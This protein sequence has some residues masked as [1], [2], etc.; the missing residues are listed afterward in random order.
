MVGL[1][2]FGAL[3][4]ILNSCDVFGQ[5]GGAAGGITYLM[6]WIIIDC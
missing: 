5:G 3:D 2:L 6:S 4:S 1:S